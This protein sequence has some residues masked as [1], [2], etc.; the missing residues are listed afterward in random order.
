MG[1]LFV[2]MNG[3]GSSWGKDRYSLL[4]VKLLIGGSGVAAIF[5]VFAI[6]GNCIAMQSTVM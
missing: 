1:I 5:V 6:T 2:G 4:D 3:R